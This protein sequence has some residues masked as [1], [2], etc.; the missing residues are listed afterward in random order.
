MS[1]A[2]R[3]GIIGDFDPAFPSHVATNDA[4]G[5]A[6]A[7]LGVAADVR[8]LPTPELEA[9]AGVALTACDGLWASPGS[10]YQSANGAYNAI[11]FARERGVPFLGT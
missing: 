7:A 8:W 5:H 11:R 1:G 9:D 4:I 3:I 2:V 6:A 10:P